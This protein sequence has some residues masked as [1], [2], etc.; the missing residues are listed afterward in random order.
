MM[1]ADPRRQMIF[2]WAPW[3]GGLLHRWTFSSSAHS[4]VACRWRTHL[5]ASA[6]HAAI[7][8]GLSETPPSVLGQETE[9]DSVN[10]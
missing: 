4:S 1:R 2:L 6:H 10:P 3:W 5:S 8:V 7:L 9:A